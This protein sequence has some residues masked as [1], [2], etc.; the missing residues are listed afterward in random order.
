[1]KKYVLPFRKK[2]NQKRR[3]KDAEDGFDFNAD[4]QS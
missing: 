3:Y 2:K 1:M 4:I